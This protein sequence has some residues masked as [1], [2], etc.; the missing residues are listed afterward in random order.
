MLP[1]IDLSFLHP[2]EANRGEMH[3]S[4]S[5]IVVAT[6]QCRLSYSGALQI[7]IKSPGSGRGQLEITYLDEEL[8]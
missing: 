7:P 2:F 3:S 8:R 5:N 4:K 1:T 6:T